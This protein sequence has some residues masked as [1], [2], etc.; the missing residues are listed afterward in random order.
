MAEV[1]TNQAAAQE[2]I[3]SSSESLKAI[4]AL[5]EEVLQYAFGGFWQIC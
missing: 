1:L 3:E 5:R 2:K 4:E